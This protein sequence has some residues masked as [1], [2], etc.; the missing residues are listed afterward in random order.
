M[1]M[2]AAPLPVLRLAVRSRLLYRYKAF[3]IESETVTVTVKDQGRR[4]CSVTT[5]KNLHNFL[6]QA[7][8]QAQRSSYKYN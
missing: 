1:I 5:I 4:A 3:L 2:I 8:A 7:Q 6:V